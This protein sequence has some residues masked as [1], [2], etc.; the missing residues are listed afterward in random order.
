MGNRG[1][2]FVATSAGEI[3]SKGERDDIHR[4]EGR[5]VERD[6]N[7]V[8]CVL[9]AGSAKVDYGAGMMDV[10]ETRNPYKNTKMIGMR[11][12]VDGGGCNGTVEQGSRFVAVATGV[13]PRSEYGKYP[14]PPTPQVRAGAETEGS[15]V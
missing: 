3:G 7:A 9:G 8:A 11:V 2:D 14:L 10:P 5:G 1:A 13:G 6:C 12:L 15:V 4:K